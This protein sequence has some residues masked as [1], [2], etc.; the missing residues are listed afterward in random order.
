M[1]AGAEPAC[2]TRRKLGPGGRPRPTGRESSGDRGG[3]AADHRLGGMRAGC[4]VPEGGGP[5]AADHPASPRGNRTDEGRGEPRPNGFGLGRLRE[6]GSCR[7]RRSGRP[8]ARL[9]G[10]RERAKRDGTVAGAASTTGH[11]RCRHNGISEYQAADGCRPRVGGRAR[12]WSPIR[13]RVVAR[14]LTVRQT[15]GWIRRR[16]DRAL[17]ARFD[18]PAA[19]CPAGPPC[20]RPAVRSRAH[21]RTARSV[22]SSGPRRSACSADDGGGRYAVPRRTGAGPASGL[23]R[24]AIGGAERRL[25]CRA[26][27]VGRGAAWTWRGPSVRRSSGDVRIDRRTSPGSGVPGAG[28]GFPPQAARSRIGPR[29]GGRSGRSSPVR[30]SGPSRCGGGKSGPR[31]EER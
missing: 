2:G 29:G 21:V 12:A 11:A 5:T 8:V 1:I 30:R 10:G 7:A 4:A 18:R 15:V 17:P 6:L 13:D 16:S 23:G 20:R 26:A 22:P 14:P 19:R 3:A 31:H 28:P 9:R 24:C 27:R 25:L